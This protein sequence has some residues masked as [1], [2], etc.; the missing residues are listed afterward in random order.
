[1]PSRKDE[2]ERSEL[3]SRLLAC[4]E[5]QAVIPQKKISTT[6]YHMAYEPSYGSLDIH[7]YTR[8]NLKC[9]AC[10]TRY[11]LEDFS[12]LDDPTGQISHKPEAEPPQ[13]FLNLDEV[14]NLLKGLD[15][16]YVILVG[17]EPALDPA[18]P[19]VTRMLKEDF[20]SHIIL[21]TNG[22]KLTDMTHI[23]EVILSI[24]AIDDDIHKDYT[25]RS[26]QKVLDNCYRISR[27]G[28]KLQ[29]ETVLIPGYL[30]AYDVERVAKYVA[31][32]NPEIP[33]RIDAYFSVSGCPWPD[34]TNKEVKKA[35]ELARKYL[36][37]ISYLTLDMKRIGDK[38][39]RIF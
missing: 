28:K 31:N 16:K 27:M 12:L 19:E 20:G 3:M 22:I 35:A 23:D 30:G 33:L 7:F 1:M 37:H 2:K 18:L 21:L 38:A 34:A 24:K 39:V 26:N 6:I 11:E 10:Y 36:R 4:P 32:I 17:T 13:R 5:A 15:I 25:G 14:K 29:I 8:C 9:R